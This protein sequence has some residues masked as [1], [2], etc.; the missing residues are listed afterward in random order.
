MEVIATQVCDFSQSKVCTLYLK[1][2]VDATVVNNGDADLFQHP[3]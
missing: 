1:G 2:I 3:H